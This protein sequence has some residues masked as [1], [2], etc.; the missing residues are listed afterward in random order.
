MSRNFLRGT[1]C[2][3]CHVS[4]FAYSCQITNVSCR[5]IGNKC[6]RF[7]LYTTDPYIIIPTLLYSDFSKWEKPEPIAQ[8]NTR[9]GS[10]QWLQA[11]PSSCL[12]LGSGLD[13][14]GPAACLLVGA[15]PSHSS[16]SFME[17]VGSRGWTAEGHQS[18]EDSMGL[19]CPAGW[20]APAAATYGCLWPVLTASIWAEVR[21]A[22][23]RSNFS[24]EV[25]A[26]GKSHLN[27]C[28]RDYSKCT[29]L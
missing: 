17:P 22:P 6:K 24:W 2:F 12:E 16:S 15:W 28:W 26:A 19:Q 10:R 23:H 5:V 29:R 3:S 8:Q 27:S 4:V 9:A 13:A 25:L 20:L 18:C 11:Q 21:H 7:W 1:V 14:L